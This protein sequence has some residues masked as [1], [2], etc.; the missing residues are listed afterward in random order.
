VTSRFVTVTA[1]ARLH[2]GFLDLNGGLGRR[3][4]SVGLAIEGFRTRVRVSRAGAPG[5]GGVAEVGRARELLGRLGGG[6]ARVEILEA[7][8]AHAGLGSGTQL[9]LALG[10]A[11]AALDGTGEGPG[12][13]ARRL[14]RGARSGIGLGAF[15]VG[16]LLVDGG[17]GVSDEPPP[18][19]SRL[20]FPEA[21]RLLLIFDGSR[22][23]LSGEAERAAFRA[24]PPFPAE[25]AARL[26]RLALMRLL[27]GVAEA[28][29]GAVGGALGEIQRA[30]GDHFAPAQG[31]RFTSPAVAGA[32]AWLE[33]EG[34]AGIGQSSW[35]PT[36]FAL[37]PDEGSAERLRRAL[38][39]R[40]RGGGASLRFAVVAG[41]NRGAE[42]AAC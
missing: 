40:S 33:A 7:I 15:G 1:P 12:E 42:T 21:W 26:C 18:I 35:G 3:F 10:T 32:L 24:L 17:K 23:G 9:G 13:V 27:P 29:I 5:V 36:G 30:V 19:L 38:A 16:G 28:D 8:P 39:E 37:L 20:D 31:G 22:R 34:V 6:P 2:L 4:G 41:R 11:L 25:T 14:E